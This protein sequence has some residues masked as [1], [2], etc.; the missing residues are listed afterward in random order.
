MYR[1][2][3]RIAKAIPAFLSLVM[4]LGVLWMPGAAS[5]A[6]RH[7]A[8]WT[9]YCPWDHAMKDDPIFLPGQKGKSPA[10]D[11]FGAM[12]ADANSTFDSLRQSQTTC[13]ANPY[14]T[15]AYYTPVMYKDGQQ[16]QAKTMFEYYWGPKG[17]TPDQVVAIPDGLKMYATADH[18]KWT[19]GGGGGVNS[20][21]F[22][23]KAPRKK[24]PFDCSPWPGSRVTAYIFLPN[25]WDG[26]GY[27]PANVTYPD[28]TTG[29]PNGDLVLPGLY[30]GEN[31][32]LA[33]GNGVT[34]S[35][36]DYTK[37]RGMY[38]EAW[39]HEEMARLIANCMVNLNWCGAWTHSGQNHPP[40]IKSAK[41]IP[42]D[43]HDTDTPTAVAVNPHD[44]DGDDYDLHYQWEVNEQGV[45]T[46]STTLD[47]SL[48]GPNDQVDVTITAE[49]VYGNWSLPVTSPVTMVEYDVTC[50]QPGKPGG[51]LQ[52]VHGGGFGPTESV[53]LRLD[54]PTGKV[55]ATV[56]SDVV[57]GFPN[58][59]VTLPLTIAGG[60]HTLYGVGADSG[61]VGYGPFTINPI[62]DMNPT[63]LAAGDSTTFTGS[64]FVPHETV[65]IAFPNYAPKS[66]QA[67][68]QGTLN[69][70]LTA[71][72]EPGPGQDITVTSSGEPIDVH[73]KV[74]ATLT[75]PD[76]GEPGVPM[77]FSLTGFGASEQAELYVDDGDSGQGFTT[78]ATGSVSSSVAVDTTFGNHQLKFLG[79]S[80]GISA[81]THVGM[82]AYVKLTPSSGPVGTTVTVSSKFGWPAND[83]VSFYWDK[84]LKDTLHPDGNGSVTTTISVPQHNPGTVVAKLTDTILNASPT[85]TFTITTFVG[86]ASQQGNSPPS[87]GAVLIDGSPYT[88][89]TFTGVAHNVKDPDGDP[90]T[91]HYTWKVN[92]KSVGGDTETYSSSSLKAGD[93]LD[94]WIRPQ[95]NHG[96]WGASVEANSPLTMKWEISAADAQPSLTSHPVYLYNYAPNETVDIKLDS[97]T[98][99]TIDTVKVNDNGNAQ[100]AQVDIPWPTTGGAHVMY[101]VGE[102][103]KIVG[104]GPITIR[105]IA[106]NV[107][108]SLHVGDTTTISGSGYKP[109][110]TVTASFPGQKGISE[111]A[112]STGSVSMDLVMPE[113]PYPGG[114]ITIQAA[115]GNTTAPY[116][117]LSSML[118]STNVAEPMDAVPFELHGYGAS[119]KVDASIDGVLSQTFTTNADGS[120]HASMIMDALFGK[121]RILLVG[122]DSAQQHNTKI[123]LP[124]HMTVT[125]D[126]AHPGDTLTIKSM[127]GWVPGDADTVYFYW[128]RQVVKVLHPDGQGSVVF[129]YQVPSNQK[130]GPVSLKLLDTALGK[131]AKYTLTIVS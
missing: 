52:N 31:W 122:R 129:T 16:V 88:N 59:D 82:P 3:S 85:A 57:G 113:E 105:P 15:S 97:P 124:P 84:Q 80:S 41:V 9:E 43:I 32:Y 27:E 29:C 112:D 92:G 53:A 48:F 114:N 125:P 130:P 61:I 37:F 11:F 33:N 119:E 42:S 10:M 121:H 44:P 45:G 54:S 101:G 39:D 78:D 26:A 118:F 72:A 116:K 117:V 131:V 58:T 120:L 35:T 102:Q 81:S 70:S 93:V 7:D 5:A 62:G 67:D 115:S 123:S 89:S 126:P 1:E 46:D 34:F 99:A 103:S 23:T 49:D 108:G 28:P 13:L 21:M 90:V 95:D 86:G 8:G 69:A 98:G 17:N 76:S 24:Y 128:G 40:K 51:L 30:L 63:S 65:T 56:Q 74:L 22:G 4:I 94:L 75:I 55:L 77:P 20:P 36:G 106:Y 6:G 127:Y 12:N 68:W 71:P 50:P 100:R 60:A 47:P 38:F 109:G 111:A 18:I 96:N 19:C 64:G 73:Y 110:E 87:I 14:D 66:F 2:R 25:C 91:L 104:Q 107:P 83:T 79:V